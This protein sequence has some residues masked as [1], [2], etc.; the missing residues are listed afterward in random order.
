MKK[1][2]AALALAFS[3]TGCATMQEVASSKETFV[4]CQALDTVTTYV[5]IQKLGF[6]E[7]NPLMAALLKHGW[8]PF[9]GFKVALIY[10][11][12]NANLSPPAQTV[13]NVVACVPGVWN[14]TLIVGQ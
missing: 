6:V 7:G 10:I 4:A 3:L 8:L 9:I 5:A 14:A 11:V 13:A 1:A 2:I 12:Y